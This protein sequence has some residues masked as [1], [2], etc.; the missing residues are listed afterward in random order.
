MFKQTLAAC[1]VAGLCSNALA[2]V[3]A[4]E[5]AQL[6]AGLTLFGAQAQANANGSIPAY[7]GGLPTSTNPSG[8][9]KDSG[10]WVNPYAAEKPLYSITAANMADYADKLSEGTKEMLRRQASYRLD[11]YPTHRSVS[12]PQFILDKTRNNATQASLGKGGD[13]LQGAIGGIPFPIPKTGQEV[14]WNHM[15]RY[16]GVAVEDHMRNFY[17]DSNGKLINSGEIKLRVIS[18][19][20][21]R[22]PPPSRSRKMTRSSSRTPTTSRVLLEALVMRRCITTPSTW[23]TCLG[24]PTPI[25]QVPGVC[26]SART[27]PTTPPS[28]RRAG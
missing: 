3:S 10:K 27:S 21:T 24:V 23:W 9:V 26:G 6:G 11:V 20:T 16:S 19:S 25:L 4:D 22:K 18:L 1:A 13:A 5:A 12:Y 15:T 8:F 7:D 2:A 17:V 28:L 14:M